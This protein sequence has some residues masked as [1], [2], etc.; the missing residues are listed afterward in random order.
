MVDVEVPDV[1]R[2][3]AEVTA[4]S[5]LLDLP[6]EPVVPVLPLET[7]DPLPAES[8]SVESAVLRCGCTFPLWE[9]VFVG[10]ASP[11]PRKNRGR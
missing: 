3:S 8:F 7:L 5:F 11:S 1:D 6:K 2:L 4:G 9:Q 10:Q